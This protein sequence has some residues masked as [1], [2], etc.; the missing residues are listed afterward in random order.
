MVNEVTGFPNL[1]R[2]RSGSQVQVTV[3]SIAALVGIK[4]T[5]VLRRDL[6]R[7]SMHGVILRPAVVVVVGTLVSKVLVDVRTLPSRW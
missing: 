2:D 7:T 5:I 1:S 3:V 6:V 4:I